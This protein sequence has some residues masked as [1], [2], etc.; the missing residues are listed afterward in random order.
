MVV[1]ASEGA[2][3]VVAIDPLARAHERLLHDPSLQFAFIVRTPPAVPEWLKALLRLLLPLRRLA[4]AMQWLFW[5]A[6]AAGALAILY[7]ISR[8]L[9][10]RRWSR[11]PKRSGPPPPPPWALD[12]ERARALLQDADRL[13]AEGRYAEAAHILLYRSID[14][15]DE[16]RPRAVHPA[17][18]ARDIARLEFLPAAARTAF[19]T[20]AEVVERSFFGGREVGE[21]DFAACRRAYEVFAFPG[22]WA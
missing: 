13:A 4:P 16:R 2:R 5:I 17:L 3:S 11:A 21:A 20:I 8:E 6:V 9:I 18:T 14:D 10:L 12:P 7:F 19:T 1:G 22:A 15:I